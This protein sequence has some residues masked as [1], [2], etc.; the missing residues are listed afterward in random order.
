MQCRKFLRVALSR[1]RTKLKT[2]GFSFPTGHI[3]QDYNVWTS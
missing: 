2:R 1:E 3:L